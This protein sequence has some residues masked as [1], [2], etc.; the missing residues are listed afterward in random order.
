[1]P[2]TGTIQRL[3]QTLPEPVPP[4][5]GRSVEEPR[6][7]Q[8]VMRWALLIVVTTL[9]SACAVEQ[10]T[11]PETSSGSTGTTGGTETDEASN[12]DTGAPTNGNGQSGTGSVGSD[13]TG[14]TSTDDGDTGATSTDDGDSP[15]GSSGESSQ[16]DSGDG[17]GDRDGDSDSDSDGSSGDDGTDS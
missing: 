12:D 13:S 10:Y 2:K 15:D 9:V 11:L 14:A 17:D 5:R 8:V 6:P 4:E 7:C 3:L 1:M 16:E